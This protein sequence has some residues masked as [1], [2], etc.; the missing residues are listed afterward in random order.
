MSAK[1]EI[2]FSLEVDHP[3]LGDV[4][5][6]MARLMGFLRDHSL[7]EPGFL[8]EFELAATEA[9]NNAVK[10]GN[11]GPGSKFVRAHL[12]LRP[13]TVELRVSDPSDFAGWTGK[14][15]LPAD[16]L[17]ESGRGGFLMTQLTD[18]VRHERGDDGHTIILEKKFPAAGC[19]YEP[20]RSEHALAEMTDE[21]VAS[22]EMI[23][24]LLGLAE[25]L[26]TAP[27]TD[28]FTAGA[29]ERLCA[30][31]GADFAYARFED[32]GQLKVLGSWGRPLHEPPDAVGADG[33]GIEAGVFRGAGERTLT[34][35]TVLP[36]DDPLA[37]LMDQGFVSPILFKDERR[38]VLVMGRTR[39][40]DFF[41]AGQLKVAR[42]L[43]E[44]LGIVVM[45]AELQR[46]RLAEERDLH[47]LAIAAGIQLS[48]MP[49][50]FSAIAS[51]DFHGVCRPARHAGG[52]YFDVINLPDGAV[53]CAVAD[54]MGKGL[55]AALLAT[56][57]RT[58]LRGLVAA[59]ESDPGAILARV[60]S[61]MREDLAQLG[62]FITM[63]CVW[64]SP[65]RDCL[66]HAGAGHPEPRLVGPDGT[67]RT[68]DPGAGGLPI[69][70]L[71]DGHYA[72]GESAF[73]PGERLLVYTDGLLEA[74]APDGAMFGEERLDGCLRAAR[75]LSCRESLERLLAEV[76]A[77][78]GHAEPSDD[79]TAV[80]VSRTG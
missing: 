56:M 31:T 66:R 33:R 49:R 8:A 25:W 75:G 32:G 51:L 63:A 64:I 59:G 19:S 29:L 13:G 47:D 4:A 76:D 5:G 6:I 79:R 71:P 20:G 38:G 28:T 1:C 45:M 72:S 12:L 57:L 77:F 70:I 62:M 73:A 41:E 16:L 46:R 14:P 69:G 39:T 17:A 67:C 27:D 55:P 78:T 44:Y 23:S 42:M 30:V 22:Y 43:A 74:T 10:H 60:N 80:L 58:G 68:L 50:D 40:A 35:G 37:G 48:L 3:G 61:L 18:E 2:G 54:V 34:V 11:A 9:L 36:P 21:L 24:S 15:E 52:D 26:A 65:D 53:L 7:S